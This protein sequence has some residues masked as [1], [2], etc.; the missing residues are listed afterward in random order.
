MDDALVQNWNEVVQP[1]DSIRVLGDFG[2]SNV[3]H[4]HRIIAQ[5]NGHKHIMLGNH[6]RGKRFYERAGFRGVESRGSLLVF[7]AESLNKMG[8]YDLVEGVSHLTV[9]LT[10][11]KLSLDTIEQCRDMWHRYGEPLPTVLNIHGHSH[12]SGEEMHGRWACIS[13][14]N[15]NYRPVTMRSVIERWLN[16]K[17]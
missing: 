7:E 10:H 17:G 15:T 14:E 6:D 11:V 16:V 2:L 8:M 1:E 9:V 4:L 3:E 13:V 12:N 5:L